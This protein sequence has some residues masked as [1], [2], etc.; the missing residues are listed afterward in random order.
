M[1]EDRLAWGAVG[2]VQEG[3][4]QADVVLV[5][6]HGELVQHGPFF[7]QLVNNGGRGGAGD[8]RHSNGSRG[9]GARG[10]SEGEA[11]WS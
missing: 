4:Q 5:V 2:V 8:S 6:H 3:A 9:W 11:A 7:N 10:Q 1:I